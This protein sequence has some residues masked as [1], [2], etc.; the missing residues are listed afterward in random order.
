MRAMVLRRAASLTDITFAPLELVDA[1]RPRCAP[2][3]VVLRVS[4]CGVCRT[5]LDLT[6]GRLVPPRYPVIPGHQIVGRVVEIGA[7]VR[8]IRDGDRRGVAWINSADG[9]CRW[10]R[11][12]NENL[13]P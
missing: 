11:A 3:G 9:C 10:C 6:E 4:V 8:E 5:D 2:D 13:C 7:Q 1:P 12:G